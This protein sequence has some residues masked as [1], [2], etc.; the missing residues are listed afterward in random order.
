MRCTQRNYV[1]L[2]Q[3]GEDPGFCVRG[4]KFGEGSGVLKLTSCQY[5]Q[6]FSGR[7]FESFLA[8]LSRR[9][10][11]KPPCIPEK[12]GLSIYSVELK[13]KKSYS[14]EYILSCVDGGD[15]RNF[16]VEDVLNTWEENWGWAPYSVGGGVAWTEDQYHQKQR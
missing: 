4:T 2:S 14:T 5:Y 8:H 13:T 7:N 9:H 11:S 6:S 1:L 16:L 12:K 3:S 15:L 10:Y